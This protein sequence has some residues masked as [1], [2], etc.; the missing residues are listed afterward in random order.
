MEEQNFEIAVD[1]G[2]E[3]ELEARNA[4]KSGFECRLEAIH[5][6]E[7]YRV[8]VKPILTAE[9]RLET[10]RLR[11]RDMGQIGKFFLRLQFNE[12]ICGVS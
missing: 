5:S 10:L 7:N 2:I 12:Q 6:G 4:E 3:L 8:V 11:F 9:R 1:Q